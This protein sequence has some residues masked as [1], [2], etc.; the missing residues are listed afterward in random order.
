MSANMWEGTVE[1]ARTCTLNNKYFV[2][3]GHNNIDLVFNV[4]YDLVAV[5]TKAQTIPS[6]ELSESQK[7]SSQF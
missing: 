2:Y 4:V 6:A 1:H 3:H 5:I 7:V